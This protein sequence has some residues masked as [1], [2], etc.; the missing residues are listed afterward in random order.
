MGASRMAPIAFFSLNI[1]STAAQLVLMR[2]IC[3]QFPGRIDEALDLISRY[4]KYCLA[5]MVGITLFGGLPSK[6]TVYARFTFVI[7][8]TFSGFVARIPVALLGGMARHA[9][10]SIC[11][12]A[13]RTGGN[14]YLPL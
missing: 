9:V 7:Q 11:G 13:C 3:M 1:G 12:T 2:Y 8:L 5:I 4:M 10:V 6:V 14:I